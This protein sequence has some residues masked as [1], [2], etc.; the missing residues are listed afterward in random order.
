VAPWCH[1]GR[2]DRRT[3]SSI[4]YYCVFLVQYEAWPAAA[5]TPTPIPASPRDT[6]EIDWCMTDIRDDLYEHYRFILGKS[7][8]DL[9]QPGTKSIL[10]HLY[11][12]IMFVGKG[13]SDPVT[14]DPTVA[15]LLYN[16]RFDKRTGRFISLNV[17][18]ERLVNFATED[19]HHSKSRHYQAFRSSHPITAGFDRTQMSLLMFGDQHHYFDETKDASTLFIP[20][21]RCTPTDSKAWFNMS[22]PIRSGHSVTV[23]EARAYYKIEPLVMDH[24]MNH[25]LS[26]VDWT[27][28]RQI[29]S[30]HISVAARL[31]NML[32]VY[33]YVEVVPGDFA[34]TLHIL[35]VID[36]FLDIVSEFQDSE[37]YVREVVKAADNWYITSVS[38]AQ[39][40]V[41]QAHSAIVDLQ[42]E[43]A[44][45]VLIPRPKYNSD[46]DQHDD[47]KTCNAILRPKWL[48]APLHK[49]VADRLTKEC[50]RRLFAT[51]G[52]TAESKHTNEE[53]APSSIEP[54]LSSLSSPTSPP[55]RPPPS[56]PTTSLVTPVHAGGTT[57]T[58]DV[59]NTSCSTTTRALATASAT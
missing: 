17:P 57:I 7:L 35:F 21:K 51:A 31:H 5:V 43:V 27:L 23:G 30:A 2:C 28:L 37:K 36:K 47:T 14:L 12:D 18:L 46:G 48:P 44:N 32:D 45:V 58:T 56:I 40:G 8:C 39:S 50:G 38:K 24:G 59:G 16:H 9:T 22:P 42:E 54:L 15:K 34:A 13:M 25:H 11:R 33:L 19:E 6:S 20:L 4:V 55:P 49:Y 29:Y 10:L 1:I 41:T 52:G 26:V 53:V 3:H